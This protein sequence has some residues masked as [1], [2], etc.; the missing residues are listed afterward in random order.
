MEKYT[1][2]SVFYQRVF[3]FFPVFVSTPVLGNEG[4]MGKYQ[5]HLA[6][7]CFYFHQC[8]P[9]FSTQILYMF[10]SIYIWLFHFLWNNCTW[11]CVLFYFS[12][13]SLLLNRNIIDFC[14][15][16]LYSMILVN[17]FISYKGIAYFLGFS[18]YITLWSVNSNRFSS[19]FSI[20]EPLFLFLVILHWIGHRL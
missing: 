4:I 14:M 10:C 19:S 15:L 9:T 17:A 8:F 16:I 5:G 11:Y 13:H 12:F 3:F 2:L 7:P 20:C 18:K 6:M 1:L